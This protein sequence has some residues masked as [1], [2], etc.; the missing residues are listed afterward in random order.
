M[1]NEEDRRQ[2]GKVKKKKIGQRAKAGKKL[3]LLTSVFLLGIFIFAYMPL[4][5]WS[6]AFIDFKP[7]IS[8]FDSKFVGLK[9]FLMPFQNAVQ[10]TQFIR[11]MKNTLGINGLYLISMFMPMAFAVLL[12]EIRSKIYRKS[13]QTLTTIPNFISWV[14]VYSGFFALLSNEGLLNNLLLSWGMIDTPVNYLA[15]T[16]FMWL[17]MLGY[18]TWKG[19]GWSAII[20]IAAISSISQELYEAAN[21]DGAGRFAKMW[22]ITIPALIPTFFVLLVLQIGNIINNGMDQYLVFSNAMTQDYIEVLD[23]YVY[24][25]GL[26]LGN[27]SYATAIGMW[28]SLVSITMIFSA[29]ALSKKFRETTIF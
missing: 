17:K 28:K 19:L 22:Y 8:I 9:W 26:K 23:L 16:S 2:M 21:V 4:I 10:R 6:Y 20:Y 11:V 3:F 27:I 5:G 12:M 29:N 13:I 15:D 25:T 7:G 14:L 18:H 24:N 1:I